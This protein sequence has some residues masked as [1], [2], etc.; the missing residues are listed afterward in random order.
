MPA[1]RECGCQQG[2]L[3]ESERAAG[4]IFSLPMYPSLTD[5]A[6]DTVCRALGEVLAEPVQI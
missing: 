2:D 4:E 5:A 6:Q 3:P 1:Y